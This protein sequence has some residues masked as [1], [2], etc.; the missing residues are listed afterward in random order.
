MECVVECL[1]CR[2]LVRARRLTSAK[3]G[4]VAI[5]FA[6]AFVPL[7][8][9]GGGA[10]DFA[11]AINSKAQLQAALDAAV[12]A[13]VQQSSNQASVASSYFTGAVA[14]AAL[15]STSPP[16]FTLNSDGSLSGTAQAQISTNFLGIIHIP[17]LPVTATATARL[18]QKSNP[19]CIL[20]LDSSDAQ[21][22]LVNSG[23]NIQAPSCEIDVRSTASP[24][25][26]FNS[27]TTL[28]VAKICVAGNN[29]TKNGGSNPPVSTGCAAISDPFA[30][31]LP[32]VS[33]GSCTY[34]NKVYDGSTVTLNPGTYCG[35]TNFNGS[36]A[37]TFNSG[38]YVISGGTMTINSGATLSGT[39]VTF[40][41]ADANSKIQFNGG[42]SGTLLAPTSGTYANILIFEPDGLGQS[43]VVFDCTN[44]ENL[45]GLIY[46][47]SRQVTFNSVSNVSSE[48][49]TM[50][51]DTLILDST[52]FSFTSSAKAMQGAA[53][54]S[55]GPYL[56]N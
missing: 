47:P 9:L 34:S 52:N 17:N 3:K 36:P 53:T 23:A 32:A 6:L 28:N 2:L 48:Q 30:G 7:V 18:N 4:N 29:V 44:G 54:A 12:L 46:L 41:F 51:V 43:Q 49:I 11:K 50:V 25:A 22:L 40:Y 31:K 39:G 15:S 21:A 38:L 55:G 16:S 42:A 45:Q 35:S 33:V 56:T 24:A 19:V 37:I 20:V 27:G 1:L 14:A 10:L 5:T 13:G 8:T 26:M